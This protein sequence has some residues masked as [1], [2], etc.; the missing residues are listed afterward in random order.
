MAPLNKMADLGRF[1]NMQTKV[2][3]SI[4]AIMIN[5]RVIFLENTG[6]S[7]TLFEPMI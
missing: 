7:V 1:N 5:Q 2:K 3:Y 6:G 4:S